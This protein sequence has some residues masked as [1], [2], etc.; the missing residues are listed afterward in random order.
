MGTVILIVCL[1]G[2]FAGAYAWKAKE[3]GK[4][5]EGGQIIQREKNFWD[6]AELFSVNKVTLEAV[7]NKFKT[8]FPE[9]SMYSYRHELQPDKNRIVINGTGMYNDCIATI[10][11][12]STD[13]DINTY[14]FIVHELKWTRGSGPN[15]LMYNIL[16]TAVEKTF[17]AFDPNVKVKT[18]F[19]DRKTK[20]KFF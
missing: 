20:R 4:Y 9:K 3:R 11:L 15:E 1:V 16:Y 8:M 12:V 6:Y 5:L 17:L 13:D 2:L 19:V 18:E 14:K 10:D 7:Y